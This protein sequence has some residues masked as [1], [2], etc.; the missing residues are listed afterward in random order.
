MAPRISNTA[1]AEYLSKA[2]TYDIAV[3]WDGPK[4]FANQYTIFILAPDEPSIV[5]TDNGHY[6]VVPTPWKHNKCNSLITVSGNCDPYVLRRTCTCTGSSTPGPTLRFI[7]K[8][9]GL[10]QPYF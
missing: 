4:V 1:P 3:S 8:I 9:L 6:Y 5:N 10:L 2:V 7:A